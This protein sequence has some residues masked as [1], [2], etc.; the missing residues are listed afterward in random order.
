MLHHKETANKRYDERISLEP[1]GE[2]KFEH[3]GQIPT[4]HIKEIVY[5]TNY[6]NEI[7]TIKS[8]D[9]ANHESDINSQIRKHKHQLL[10]EK[11]LHLNAIC[12]AES[13]EIKLQ[14]E[15]RK[16]LLQEELKTIIQETLVFAKKNHQPPQC[17]LL[18]YMSFLKI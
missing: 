13:R 18:G 1:S 16:K 9:K 8:F 14:A 6:L 17:Y 5:K 7:N 15:N 11:D 12:Q 10:L 3:R 4:S 2:L